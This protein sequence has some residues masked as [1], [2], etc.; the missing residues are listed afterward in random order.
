MA[1]LVALALIVAGYFGWRHLNRSRREVVDYHG[2]D[3]PHA[4]G[5]SR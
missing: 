2:I 5:A 4:P 1:G 3:T